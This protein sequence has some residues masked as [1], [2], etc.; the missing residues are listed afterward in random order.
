MR[1]FSLILLFIAT[2][3]GLAFVY[4]LD[5]ERREVKE[6]LKT[7]QNIKYGLLN[8]DEW[9]AITGEI[10]RKKIDEFELSS[11]NK[12]SLRTEIPELLNEMIDVAE[13]EEYE[14]NRQKLFGGLLTNTFMEL[15]GVFNKLRSSIPEMTEKIIDHME[16][17]R[18]KEG[19]KKFF[20]TKL[21]EYAS[22][23]FSEIDYSEV[24]RI[25]LKYGAEDSEDC[26]NLLKG[27]L[28]EKQQFLNF[29]KY[30]LITLGLFW[31][32]LAIWYKNIDRFLIVL[33]YA[34]SGVFLLFGLVLPM[35]EIEAS[36]V[37]IKFQMLG[38][39]IEFADQVL[40]Y[41]SKSVLELVSILFSNLSFDL[42]LVGFLVVLFSVI[43]PL[44]KLIFGIMMLYKPN[45]ESKKFVRTLVFKTAKWSMSD[46][47]VVSMFMAYLGISGMIGSQMGKIENSI[48]DN[49]LIAMDDSEIGIGFYCYLIFVL[50]GI[51]ISSKIKRMS[52]LQEN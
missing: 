36:I 1:K 37:L 47:F 13:T 15:A 9:K 14:R 34:V 27:R 2:T 4:S 25:T 22:A 30:A 16:K 26:K 49:E 19:L 41:R 48:V 33:L 10:I 20:N 8:V 42:I 17:P 43:F 46:V 50:L 45:L 6:D 3:L 12:E 44:M 24:D 40:Y 11:K 32:S 21:D 52:N 18:T 38:Q 29:I 28:G 39:N 7:I 31:I 35:I 23:T 5:Q 51:L